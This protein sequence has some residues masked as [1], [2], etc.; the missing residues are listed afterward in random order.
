MYVWLHIYLFKEL[1]KVVIM[2]TPPVVMFE[3]KLRLRVNVLSLALICPKNIKTQI[4]SHLKGLLI[5]ISC[6][7]TPIG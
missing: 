7:S 1:I 5:L 4:R 2:V 6:Q 3:L